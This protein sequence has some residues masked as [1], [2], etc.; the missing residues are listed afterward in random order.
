MRVQTFNNNKGL[1]HGSDPKRMG[2]DVMGTL[3]I[4][5][6]E[7]VI[8]EEEVVMPILFNGCNGTYA[9]TYTSVSGIV[10]DLGKITVKG[11]R[12]VPPSQTTVELMELRCRAEALE[13]E[14]EALREDIRR[15][16]N[17]FD[18]DSLNFLIK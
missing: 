8:S 17:I 15:L 11:G 3:R 4:G 14:C 12:I 9:G 1:I 18:T 16:S 7:I 2:C 6:A 10:Y 5:T 13:A